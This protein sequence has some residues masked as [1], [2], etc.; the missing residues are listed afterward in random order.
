MELIRFLIARS[1]RTLILAVAF[2]LAGGAANSALL[3]F[4][5]VAISHRAAV[6][7]RLI[8]LFIVLCAIAPA[9][10]VISELLLIRLGQQVVYSL[11]TQLS[12]EVLAVPLRRLEEVGP[13]RILSV[14]T[15]DVPAITNMVSTIP[16]LCINTGVVVSCLV[17]MGW[18]NW[19]LLGAVLGVV[20]LGIVTYQ[21]GVGRAI[22]HFR[23]A[24]QHENDLQKH[25]QGLVHGIKEL[26]LHHA[27]RQTF[28][29]QVL[30]NT[31]RSVQDENVSALTIY[32]VAASWGQ[33]LVF[34]TIGAVVF[35][36]AGV[37]GATAA[38]VTGFALAL[39]YVMSP[40][41]VVMNSVPG[42]ARANLAVA[43]VRDLGLKLSEAA[44]PEGDKALS[45]L[46]A[47]Q[48]SLELSGVM[49]SYY[50]EDAQGEFTLG[51]IDLKVVPGEL[52]FITGGNGSGKTTLAKLMMGLYTPVQGTIRCNGETITDSNRAGYRQLF[53]A[54]FSDFFLF[55]S[56]LG[57]ENSRLDERARELLI[58]L[59]LNH[60]VQV[61]DGVLSTTELS[62]GQRKRLALLTACLE[63]R[64][65]CFFDEWAADQDPVFKEFFYLSI[66]P[67]LK[68]RG[69]TVLVITHDD[70]YFGAADRIVHLESGRITAAMPAALSS[71]V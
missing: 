71:A 70:R 59:R 8:F 25:F 10:R 48:V 45:E 57:L 61:N 12:R 53:S 68:D 36:L 43:N 31:A 27:R 41:Q 7:L 18:L 64:P 35:F 30:G 20:A 3:A 52:L 1:R 4:L 58:K 23:R 16:V 56:L 63:D 44:A 67:G 9:V 55:N 29:S 14:L 62:H 51:P 22:Q 42:I 33:L 13:H 38:A 15:D 19:K 47:R 60:K 32:T 65:I 17:Y 24:R 40:L 69:K 6:S 28:L 21:L 39:L 50:Q 26:K 2:G 54:V 37:L 5:N 11:R 49:Y 46:G 34:V 66:L